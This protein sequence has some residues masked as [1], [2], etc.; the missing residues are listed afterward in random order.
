M[1][2][3]SFIIP[4]SV[5]V[6]DVNDNAPAWRGAPYR[7]RVSELAAAG[8]RVLAAPAADRDQGAHGTVRYAVLPGPGS[9]SFMITYCPLLHLYVTL[10]YL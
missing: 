4:T 9:V 2:L 7:A 3:Q 6:Y 5:R 8:A 10:P 1:L